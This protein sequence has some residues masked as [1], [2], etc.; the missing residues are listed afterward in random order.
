MEEL[1]A[2][3][4]N[5]QYPDGALLKEGIK[6]EYHAQFI[7]EAMK[8]LCYIQ[9]QD[10]LSDLR[11]I[12]GYNN[13]EVTLNDFCDYFESTWPWSDYIVYADKISLMGQI[14]LLR[15]F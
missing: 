13:H 5:F 1:Q 15:L 10:F 6:L 11:Q 12:A 7:R 8:P 2:I 14:N 4:E 3:S 9:I